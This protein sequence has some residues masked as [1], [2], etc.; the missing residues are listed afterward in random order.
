MRNAKETVLWDSVNLTFDSGK[1]HVVLGAPGAG[2]ATL[3]RYISN[4]RR[5][6]KRPHSGRVSVVERNLV[7]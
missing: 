1:W 5:K 2:K 3:L 4:T 7:G 6:E